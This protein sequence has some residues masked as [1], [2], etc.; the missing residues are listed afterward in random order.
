MSSH[1]V[2]AA[3]RR[4]SVAA[5]GERGHQSADEL[6]PMDKGRPGQVGV[7]LAALGIGD[8][9]HGAEEFATGLPEVE[10]GEVAFQRRLGVVGPAVE[11]RQWQRERRN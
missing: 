11:L 9:G 3:V 4:I 7:L 8:D 10:G 1:G 2:S 5:R 6:P